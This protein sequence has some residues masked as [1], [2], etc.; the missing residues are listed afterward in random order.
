MTEHEPMRTTTQD[1]ADPARQPDGG[2]F[3]EVDRLSRHFAL[4]QGLLGGR[5]ILRAVDDVSFAIARG[6]TL[7]LVGE[8]GSGK[9]TVARM[10]ARLTRPTSGRVLLRGRDVW[11]GPAEA[12]TA[13]PRQV[14][15]IF[16]DPYSSL[17]PRKRV[18]WTVAEGLRVQGIGTAAEQRD[19]VREVMDWV[20]LLPEHALRYPHE[21]SGGQR[22]RIAIARA[23]V[24]APELVVCDE[25]VS[26]L[27]VSI[28]AQVLNLLRDMQAKLGLTYL[29][30][31]HDL[32][33]VS[34]VSDRVAVM[35][36][37]RIVELA[38]RDAIY[39]NPLHPY[40]RALLAAVPRPDPECGPDR[41]ATSGQG[42]LG[43]QAGLV[44]LA[45]D[46]PDA[47]CPFHPRC[48]EARDACRDEAP[49][50]REAVP[51]HFVSC[52]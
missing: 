28:Q 46:R 42:A 13:L 49:R 1:T 43:G 25:P 45:E 11:D 10:I 17:N 2:P 12:R 5:T 31:S 34:H 29:F 20:G 41:A 44:G 35:Y 32:A 6:E 38:G 4:R 37:G 36:L 22:Q 21:F 14:Q 48:P 15:M 33:V 27:D 26:S 50:L 39:D 23:L 51:G 40:T 16:Q 30:I 24:L 47:G 52:Y 18:G 19:R 9:S 7:G 8:S 3:L